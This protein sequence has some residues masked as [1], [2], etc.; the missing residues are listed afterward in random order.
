MSLTV[1][2]DGN[3]SVADAHAIAAYLKS[4]KPVSHQVP[5]PFGPD[6]KPP[7]FRMKVLPPERSAAN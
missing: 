4:L 7:V 2:V 3:V 6:E 5:G 1:A